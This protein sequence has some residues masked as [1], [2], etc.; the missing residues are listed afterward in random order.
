VAVL[1]ST[2]KIMMVDLVSGKS[3][4]I[5]YRDA[6]ILGFSGYFQRIYRQVAPGPTNGSFYLSSSANGYLAKDIAFDDDGGCM[7]ITIQSGSQ[8]RCLP[9]LQSSAT[10]APAITE[11]SSKPAKEF[12][13][14]WI[15]YNASQQMSGF[16]FGKFFT[17]GVVG[18]SQGEVLSLDLNRF[19]MF[20]YSRRQARLGYSKRISNGSPVVRLSTSVAGNFAAA[21]HA[22]NKVR[23]HW[24]DQAFE[25]PL[26]NISTEDLNELRDFAN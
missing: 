10:N 5:K 14:P 17:A 12:L 23:L 18:T 3:W 25:L 1:L 20:P 22:D 13:D 2:G 19:R 26:L 6:P 8:V 21:I 24:I 16:S 9:I 11:L 4:E 7:M 15:V